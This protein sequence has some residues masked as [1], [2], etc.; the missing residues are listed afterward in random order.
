MFRLTRGVNGPGQ[1]GPGRA[2]GATGRPLYH[3]GCCASYWLGRRR[4]RV[5][6]VLVDPRKDG[7]AQS[8]RSALMHWVA[9]TLFCGDASDH[10][11]AV[12]D[13]HFTT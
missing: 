11:S 6:V 8:G 13:K 1:P 3:V 2:V 7:T 5:V 10:A 4:R 9:R 12:V